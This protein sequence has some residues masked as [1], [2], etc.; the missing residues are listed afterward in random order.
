MRGDSVGDRLLLW[1]ARR[2]PSRAKGLHW[3]VQD[4]RLDRAM[5]RRAAAAEALRRWG[6]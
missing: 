3:R 2:F 4:H 5:A 1:L 6:R